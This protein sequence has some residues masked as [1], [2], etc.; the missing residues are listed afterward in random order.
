MH[1]MR[2]LVGVNHL[3][4]DHV[5]HNGVLIGNTI[6]TQHIPGHPGHVQRLAA[7]VALDQLDKL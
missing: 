6:A 3:K 4:I 7:G 1:V 2:A 5:S